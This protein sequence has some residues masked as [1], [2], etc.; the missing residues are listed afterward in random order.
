MTSPA[1]ANAVERGAFDGMHG[2][3]TFSLPMPPSINRLYRAVQGRAILSKEYRV[4]KSEAA[5]TL[6]VQRCKPVHGPVS[7]LV[8]CKPADKR[9]RDIDNVGFKAVLDLL[10]TQKLID[11]D[12]SSVV[13]QITARW[14]DSGPPCR[15]TITPVEDAK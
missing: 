1:F 12:D 10:V 5:L 6:M 3:V 9:R 7:V 2:H 11:A 8:E 13:K 14:V 4:W 15:V